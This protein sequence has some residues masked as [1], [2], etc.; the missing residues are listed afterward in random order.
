LKTE[1]NKNKNENNTLIQ[2]YG[3]TKTFGYTTAVSELDLIVEK[4]EVLA[5][6]GANGAGKSTLKNLICG[7]F[8]P[9]KG[10]LY[11]DGQQIDLNHYSPFLAKQLGIRAVHQE[12]SLCKNLSVYE[13]FYVENRQEFRG[14]FFWWRKKA[15][16]LSHHA[17]TSIFPT[18][19][20]DV[21][22]ILGSLSIAQQQMVE[23]ARAL[24]DSK[25]KLIILDEP[26]SS[27]PIEETNHLLNYIKNYKDK[28][29]SFVFVSHRLQE[30]MD[31]AHHVLIMQNGKELHKCDIDSTSIEDMVE[32]MSGEVIQKA[33]IQSI[34]TTN[35]ITTR[36]SIEFSNYSSGMLKNIDC[37][38]SGGQIVGITGLEGNG[39]LEFLKEIFY[40]SKKKLQP[41]NLNISGK[42]VYIAGDRKKEGIFPLW[43]I[44]DNTII[45]DAASKPFFSLLKRG[46]ISSLV[47]KWNN[48]LKTKSRSY[49]DLITSLSG[50]NQQKVL[51]A[52][53][54]ASEADIILLDDPTKGV[55][56]KTKEEL[57][58]IFQEA[59]ANGKLIIWRSSDDEEL[60]YCTN[61][62]VMGDGK[63]LGEFDQ[64]DFQRTDMLKL[65]FG[66][67]G[68]K[69]VDV[70]VKKKK[71]NFLFLFALI[72][73]V[74]LY[75]TCGMLSPAVFSK[76]GFELLAIGF[77]PF[78]FGA[79]AQTFI[80][81]L[82]HID[83]SVGAFMGLINVV[84][85]TL[86][87]D[88]PLLGFLVLI[89]LLLA[90]SLMGLLVCWRSIP[91]IV[92]TLSMSFV[93]TGLA[94]V[95]QDVPGGTVPSWMVTLFNFNNPIL[96]GVIL[97][98]FVFV[99]IA[100]YIYRSRY[101]TV[102][103]GFGNNE[104]AMINSGWSKYRA[105]WL[106]YL[107]AGCFAFM[108]GVAESAIIVAS[109]IN[110]MS[111]YTLLT[112]AAVIIGGGYFS[113]GVVTHVGAVLGSVIL[114]LVSILLG[115]FRVSTDY[116]ATIQG[117]VLITILSLRLFQKEKTQ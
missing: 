46:Y 17:I 40:S 52:R 71:L 2:A 105:Y 84:C 63:I 28:E 49:G 113:G 23:I 26:T 87:F 53:A 27:L 38:L 85:A 90:Y 101:G 25:A 82:G 22:A 11:V 100:V 13:N 54:L 8:P 97:W 98:M 83:L 103:R 88:T 48:R 5:L 12:L 65:T 96:Q 3:L 95:L 72:A 70:E 39:Q 68:K 32:K 14:K 107:I 19:K 56:V 58:V 47:N 102:L 86:L 6:I 50:G 36:T 77:T 117:F 41:N 59:A 15:R 42:V 4:G 74:V 109:D 7:I 80:I 9:D 16:D 91:P 18:S 89:A 93:W 21:D 45:T 79:L 10:E 62:I 112:V 92:I 44:S 106:T 24:F 51:I 31:I 76:F 73:T 75:F 1:T 111:T 20:I 66:A 108:G 35:E 69:K 57:Y 30:V 29:K 81:G 99:G 116:T 115:L 78:I 61:L 34:A 60:V 114:T 37:K 94:Y 43:S 110:A 64:K 67:I 55:D 104:S 33:P